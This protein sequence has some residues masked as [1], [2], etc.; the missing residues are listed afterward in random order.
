MTRFSLDTNPG[1]D[2]KAGKLRGVY[3]GIVTA[4]TERGKDSKYRIKVKFPWLASQGGADESHWAR[5]VVPMAGAE[6]GTYFLPQVDDQ[7]L[8][9]FEHGD[10][11]RPIIMG[12]LWSDKQKPPE[13]N[14]DGKN[15]IRVIKSKTGHRM[16]FDDTN[17]KERV[18]LTDSTKKNTITL[19]SANKAV[20]VETASGDIEI[21]AAMGAARFHGKTVNIT[22]KQNFAGKGTLQLQIATKGAVKV[23]GATAK[24]QGVMTQNLLSA[25]PGSAG[26][27]AVGASA[28]VGAA[29]KPAEQVIEPAGGES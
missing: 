3:L 22:T 15:H 9:V 28:A 6:R 26:V 19:D 16:I 24:L 27:P 8:V 13:A 5:I 23:K 20:T 11:R 25:L 14:G 29:P 12:S 10:I 18:I 2:T 17:G 7:V 21:K 1:R 4:N